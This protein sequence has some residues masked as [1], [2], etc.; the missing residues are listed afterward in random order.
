VSTALLTSLGRLLPLELHGAGGLVELEP[1]FGVAPLER[2]RWGEGD[3]VVGRVTPRSPL[4]IPFELPT[5]RLVEAGE[6]D[7]VLG[8]LGTRAATLEVVGD[9]RAVGADGAL[10]ALT[11]AGLMGQ[12]TS[13]SDQ[14][15]DLVELAYEGHLLEGERPLR[16]DDFVPARGR[17]SF[18]LPVVLIVGSSM[19]AGKTT[20]GRRLVRVL[21]SLGHRVLAAKLT[22]AARYRDV[23]SLGDA[24]AEW[25]FDFVDAGL[26]STVC[27]PEVYRAKL[28]DLL[29]RM[30]E[31]PA[32]VAV[33]EAGASPLEPYNGSV[34]F[35][36]LRPHLA[37]TV[38]C[39]SDPYAV[40]GI[41]DAFGH[42]PDLVAGPTANTEAGVQLVKRL[43]QVRALDARQREAEPELRR[44]LERALK[45]ACASGAASP[46]A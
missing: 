17:G 25:I 14:V 8:A 27:E 39:A 6:G 22:G 20:T 42:R 5:G 16:M 9:W 33:F 30:G 31:L 13:K 26:P 38:L 23:L 45:S 29:A 18:S 3:Y 40:V 43:A 41:I 46:P 4:R 44:L 36:E 12:V 24:G 21:R 19:S 2:T 37:C 11:P 28:R 15:P 10:Q 34:A 7:R 32:D 35:E 1:R